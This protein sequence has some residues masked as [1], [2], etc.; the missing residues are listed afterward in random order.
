MKKFYIRQAKKI[1]ENTKHPNGWIE[2]WLG[3]KLLDLD[4]VGEF[5][6]TPIMTVH[7]KEIPEED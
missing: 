4:Y 1:L 2:F 6:I 3:D 7:L 5:G